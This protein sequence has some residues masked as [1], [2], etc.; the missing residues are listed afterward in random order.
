[1]RR[2]LHPDGRPIRA[3]QTQQV[4][5]DRAVALKPL[6]E[7]V[8]RLRI[9][10]P[11]ELERPH[12]LLRR[13]RRVAEHQFQKRVGREGQRRGVRERADVHA[14]VHRL[15]QPRECFRRRSRRRQGRVWHL[16]GLYGTSNPNPRS[17]ANRRRQSRSETASRVD[18]FPAAAAS[19]SSC[20]SAGDTSSIAERI[21]DTLAPDSCI[22]IAS[23]A[24]SRQIPQVM[25]WG[26]H[27]GT[28]VA[29]RGS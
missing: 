25:P 11:L 27:V 15:E 23:R 13:L 7:S 22:C 24:T 17:I 6:D 28:S 26:S 16:G 14:L 8:A 5:G 12:V 1:M 2:D 18:L 10:E 3:A 4:I 29:R 21:C 19:V 9:D 20:R